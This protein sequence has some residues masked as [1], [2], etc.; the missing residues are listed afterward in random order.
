MKNALLL[1][2]FIDNLEEVAFAARDTPTKDGELHSGDY[3]YHWRISRANI[4]AR[5]AAGDAGW[6]ELWDGQ[7]LSVAQAFAK[8]D[9]DAYS[10]ADV[11]AFV[12]GYP[13]KYSPFLS[14][15]PGIRLDTTYD[16]P[17][18]SILYRAETG[19]FL[20]WDITTGV[21]TRLGQETERGAG[22]PPLYWSLDPDA[23]TE[24]L[25]DEHLYDEYLDEY[26]SDL[27]PDAQVIDVVTVAVLSADGEQTEG[28]VSG[29]VL[30]IIKDSDGMYIT[31]SV[32]VMQT[33]IS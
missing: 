6:K 15:T 28:N 1:F 30:Y 23:Q 22:E 5:Y 18:G 19:G 3:T 7:K 12:A 31:E 14:S 25:F 33:T 13:E 26:R 8:I 10:R 17:P 27:G 20:D 11:S 9:K 24:R 16:G 2:A 21:I 29:N 32:A 4:A